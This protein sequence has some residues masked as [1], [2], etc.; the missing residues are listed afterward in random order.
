MQFW[1]W[2]L[3]NWL[4]NQ[5]EGVL[6]TKHSRA[7]TLL[8]VKILYGLVLFS[9]CNEDFSQIF[10]K[11]RP[12]VPFGTGGLDFLVLLCQDKRTKG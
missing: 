1:D 2:P 7:L 9:S 11:P 10:Q 3:K 8:I 12:N 6:K 4:R 5:M